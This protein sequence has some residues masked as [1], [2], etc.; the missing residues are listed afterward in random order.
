MARAGS[1]GTRWLGVGLASALAVLTLWLVATDRFALFVNPAQTPFAIAMAIIVLM[2][3]VASFALP[4]GAE[5]DHGHDHGGPDEQDDGRGD[6]RVGARLAALGGGTAATLVVAAGVLLPPRSLSVDLALER[7]TGSAPLFG[8][9][10]EVTFAAS[11]D[12][13]GFGVGGWAAVFA[14]STNP[15]TFD[16]APV[17]L[18]GF[19]TPGDAGLR[20]GRLVITHCVID[21]QPASVPVDTDESFE[22]GQW[23]TI[24]GQVAAA[25]DGTLTIEPNE[26]APVDEPD[27]P[28]E[29]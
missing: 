22:K 13:A 10:E 18:T 25:S 21:A 29:Y 17:E 7:D 24:T 14:R 28:Y 1:I 20:L 5:S 6:E 4:L 19:V 16:G 26:I 12:T 27:D 2:S 8:G 23:V 3:A 9:A 11:V 15:D